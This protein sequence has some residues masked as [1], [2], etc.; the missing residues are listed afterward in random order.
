MLKKLLGLLVVIAL[1]VTGLYY[2][3]PEKLVKLAV[4]GERAA[5]SLSRH[6]IDV[7]GLKYVYLEGGKGEPLVLI[8]GF[9][10][11][12]ENFTRVAKFLTPR[13]HVIIPDLPGFGESGKPADGIYTV[14]SQVERV[15]ALV[16]ALGLKTV[17]LGG[18]SMGGNIA[19]SYAAKYPTET[20]SIWL[21]A[22]A[23]LGTAPPSDVELS[24]KDGGRNP[25]IAS[26][27]D[28][29]AAVFKFVMAD[30]PF[31]PRR[32]IDVMGRTA[33]ANHE[34][35]AKIFQQI[36]SEPPLESRVPG[37]TVPARIVWGDKD[38]ALNVGG[39]KILAGLMPN[40]SVLIL[41][42][43][44]HL[45]MLERPREVAADYLTFRDGLKAP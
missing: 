41:P 19:A 6:E 17:H 42:G 10:A 22:P 29:F 45:P 3:C 26:N 1:V 34:L 37:L 44:G 14:A 20:A 12:K 25:L 31:L 9:G 36:R 13:F 40:A 32:F 39:A 11:D 27:P 30:P 38:R 33:V 4:E 28:E 18:S 16:Q 7:A 35:N 24:L 43:I 2:A 15:H 23:G 5:A 21:L 8:H